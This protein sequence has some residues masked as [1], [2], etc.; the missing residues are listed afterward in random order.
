VYR[1][2]QRFPSAKQA[3]GV[4]I[5]RFAGGL[6]FVNYQTLASHLN[7]LVSK[8]VHTVVLDASAIVS[9]DSSALHGI[10]ELLEVRGQ[11]MAPRAP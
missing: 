10:L 8:D 7:F 4:K 5:V 1:D 11:V 6:N 2:V 9:I 3:D